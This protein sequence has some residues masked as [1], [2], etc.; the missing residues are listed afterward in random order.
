MEKRVIELEKKIAFQ[1]VEIEKLNEIVFAHQKMIDD[2][3]RMLKQLK[4]QIL[5][6]G[7]VKDIENEEPP[8]HY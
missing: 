7:L 5:S 1:D 4:E 3:S 8:P 2:L 6:S